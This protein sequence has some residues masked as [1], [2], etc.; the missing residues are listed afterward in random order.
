MLSDNNNKQISNKSAN[1]QIKVLDR[2][3]RK[4]TNFIQV[5]QVNISETFEFE[6]QW[7][8]KY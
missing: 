1:I 8:R 6:R 3:Y 2:T 5:S 7:I 4:M